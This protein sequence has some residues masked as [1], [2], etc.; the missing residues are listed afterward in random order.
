[1]TDKSQPPLLETLQLLEQLKDAFLSELPEKCEELNSLVLSLAQQQEKHEIYEELYRS[2]HSLKGA[3]GT[4]D[5]L[6]ISQICHH[7]ED[8]LGT[9]SDE[10]T[11]INDAF[12][13][14]CLSYVD[15]IHE[16]IS[17]TQNSSADFTAIE[18][19]LE[20]IRQTLGK[21]NYRGL[22]VETSPMMALMYKDTL[23]SLPVNLS[24]LDNGLT[25]LKRLLLE[26]F[27]FLI[28]GKELKLLNGV[29]L[30]SALRVSDSVNSSIPTIMV[31]SG[32]RK[33]IPE[34]GKP[35]Y[36]INRDTH[37]TSNLIKAVTSVISPKN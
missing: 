21:D 2:V 16:A 5:L 13:N 8:L 32:K 25:A 20:R 33:S 11:Q 19:E 34:G 6:I 35:D 31:T 15:L 7:F 14:N 18:H 28:L 12:T 10:S 30:I 27:D 3:A 36:R 17:A 29:A 22:I 24:L 37:L 9:L 4:H 23:S 1:M 26:K